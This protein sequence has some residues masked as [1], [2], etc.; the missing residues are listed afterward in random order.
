MSGPFS[1]DAEGGAAN[2]PDH[3][4]A[5]APGKPL[6]ILQT[7]VTDRF[8][9][10]ARSVRE[11]AGAVAAAGGRS[12]IAASGAGAARVRAPGTDLTVMEF[13]GGRTRRRAIASLSEIASDAGADVIHAHDP[14]S[15]E[16]AAAAAQATGAAFVA[17]FHNPPASGWRSALSRS[18]M[19]QAKQVIAV[20]DALAQSI[21]GRHGLTSDRIAVIP[22]GADMDI[23]AEEVVSAHRTIALADALGLSEDPRPVVLTMGR[24]TKTSGHRTLVQAV[25]R[26][27]GEDALFLL[28]GDDEDGAGA[29]LEAEIIAA[30]LGGAFRRALPVDDTPAALKLASMVCEVS[31]THGGQV[32]IE[33]QAMGRPVLAP[34]AG[35][36]LEVMVDGS[37]GWL[38]PADDVEALNNLLTAALTMDESARAHIGMAGRARVRASF[39]LSTMLSRALTVYETT[40]GAAFPNRDYS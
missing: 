28:V 36:A 10:S 26:G 23:Y 31:P 33:A 6:T 8:T 19:F 25:A 29:A 3:N 39:T 18:P 1:K 16:A 15:A 35:A 5:N 37:S 11:V 24:I 34:A 32:L 17:T 13:G 14:V 22:R 12:L 4:G 7:I 27:V 9:A 2:A 38:Y 30:G 21:T 40:T 20:S